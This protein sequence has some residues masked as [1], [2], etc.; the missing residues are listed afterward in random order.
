VS[1]LLGF[2][3]SLGGGR[4]GSDGERAA[5]GRPAGRPTSSALEPRLRLGAVAPDPL[6]GLLG[7]DETA[8]PETESS[9]LGLE[10]LVGEWLSD[11]AIQG[12][13]PQTMDWYHKWRRYLASGDVTRLDQLTGAELKRHLAQL[14]GRGLSPE[15]VHGHFASLRAFAGWAAREN[16]PVDPSLFGVRPPKV[17]QKEMETYSEDQLHDPGSRSSRLASARHVDPARDRHAGW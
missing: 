9:G 2:S 12:R 7:E 3:K 4:R 5:A 13:S 17:P 10:P 15:S 16:Y 1:N 6:R 8:E 11:L 14:Q